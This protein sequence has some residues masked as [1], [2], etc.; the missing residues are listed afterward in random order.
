[1]TIFTISN[2]IKLRIKVSLMAALGMDQ[3]GRRKF[4]R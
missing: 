4:K 1:M 2:K 3:A